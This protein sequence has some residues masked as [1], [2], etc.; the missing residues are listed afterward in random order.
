[1]DNLIAT[2]HDVTQPR[3]SS[4]LLACGLW[5]RAAF[6]GASAVAVGLIQ[7]FEGEWSWPRAVLCAGAGI[8]VCILSWHR[9]RAALDDLGREATM[10]G[11]TPAVAHQ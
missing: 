6:I 7:L 1:M 5:M 9:A 10:S 11:A 4:A 2:G 3:A 8:A